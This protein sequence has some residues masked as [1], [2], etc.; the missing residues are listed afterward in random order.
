MQQEMHLVRMD[1]FEILL[2]EAQ[3]LVSSIAILTF[4]L[5]AAGYLYPAVHGTAAHWTAGYK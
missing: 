1:D 2:C 5:A 4:V 3:Q